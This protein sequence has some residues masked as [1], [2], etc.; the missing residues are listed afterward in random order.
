MFENTYTDQS[1]GSVL[2]FCQAGKFLKVAFKYSF[3]F[4]LIM[5]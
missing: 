5:S 3:N 1:I 2:D 4:S